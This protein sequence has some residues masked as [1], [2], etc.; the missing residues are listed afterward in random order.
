MSEEEQVTARLATIEQRLA[1]IEARLDRLEA[2]VAR[3]GTTAEA[4]QFAFEE[5]AVRPVT[6][7][8]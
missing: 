3:E 8:R 1:R 2:D 5:L 6:P 7:R 4:M